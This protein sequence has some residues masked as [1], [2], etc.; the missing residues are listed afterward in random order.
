MEIT[1]QKCKLLLGG[2][3]HPPSESGQQLFDNLGKALDVYFLMR[4]PQ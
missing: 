1:F 2:L 4:K 3:Y